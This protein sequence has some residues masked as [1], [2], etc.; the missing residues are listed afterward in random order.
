MIFGIG[1]DVLEAKRIARV[2]ARF[3]ERFVER[4]LMPAE[5]AQLALTQRPNRFLAMRFAAKEA[6]VK[7]MGTG[8]AQG[9][10]IRDVG[11]VQNKWGKPEVVYS[12][13]GDKVRRRLGVGQG[14]VTLTD[15]AGL[16]VAV[17]VL[18]AAPKRVRR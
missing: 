1:V 3:G 2:H 18:E 8:F 6:I 16:I 9:V 15:E 5:A 13:R 11:V 7:A 10:W 17:A 12:A 4:L 14:H